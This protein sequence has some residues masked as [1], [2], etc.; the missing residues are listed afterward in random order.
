MRI[1]F[2]RPLLLVL[3]TLLPLV[4]EENLK[5][6][7]PAC[8]GPVFDKKY[9]VICYDPEHKIPSWVG[10]SLT[11]EDLALALADREESAFEFRSDPAVPKGQ[12]AAN[13]DYAKSGYDKGHM[14]PAA[15]FERS[16]AA[17]KAT[18]VLSNAVPQKHGINAGEWKELEKAVRSLA[19]S[20]GKV[21]VFSGPVFT[22]NKPMKVIGRNHVAVPTHTYKVILCVHPNDGKE[23]FAFVMPNLDKPNGRIR[24]YTS[25]VDHVEKLTGLNFFSSLPPDE[26]RRLERKVTDLPVR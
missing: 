7:Q 8:S 10:Y 6:G 22:G 26:Q 3:A 13:S 4:A 23:M 24:D 21:W 20:H 19:K 5:Y 25:S 14:A 9:F 12:R 15:D 11:R 16:A 2:C 1:S 17:M 18:F